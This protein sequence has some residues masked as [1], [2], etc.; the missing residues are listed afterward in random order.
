L[1]T[2]LAQLVCGAAAEL[3][4]VWVCVQDYFEELEEAICAFDPE[5][6]GWVTIPEIKQAFA[7]VDP[8]KPEDSVLAIMRRGLMRDRPKGSEGY[9]RS[10]IRE[11]E[12][13]PPDDQE[14]KI[15]EFMQ[16][17]RAV[18]VS[19][20]GPKQERKNLKPSM[21][22][23]QTEKVRPSPQLCRFCAHACAAALRMTRW[24]LVRR[25]R[26]WARCSWLGW[27][28]ATGLQWPTSCRSVSD[29][30]ALGHPLV[31]WGSPVVPCTRPILGMII[32]ETEPEMVPVVEAATA[33][34]SA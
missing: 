15:I 3:G 22:D 24:A 5:A 31:C 26:C 10:C 17:I 32:A 20:S 34:A 12:R 4:W 18:N 13:M 19:R 8:D 30:L 23:L 25:R 9:P 27:G 16:Q 2:H 7:A 21:L 33:E 6:D 14:F 1:R 28:K 29:Q 11:H